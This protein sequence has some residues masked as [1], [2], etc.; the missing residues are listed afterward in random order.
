MPMSKQ[1]IPEILT[2]GVQEHQAV[3]A[4]LQIQSG[5]WEPG[6]LEV[7]QQRRYSTVYRLKQVNEEAT[8]VIAK[9]CRVAT[10]RI[11]QTIYEQ[12][13]PLTRMPALCC[14]GLQEESD[15]EFCWLFL[16]DAA[17]ARYSPQLPHNRGLAGR[18][19]AE[20]QLAAMSANLKSYLP[21]RELDHYLRLLRACRGMLLDHLGGGAFLAED[22]ALLRNIAAHLDALESLWGKVEKICEVMPRTLVH[23]DFVTKNLRVR[24]AAASPAL[25]VFDWE[26]AGWGVPATDLAQFIDRV[27]SPDLNLYCSILKGGQAH[28][29]LRDIQAVAACGNLLRMIDQIS[30]AT[31]DQE[32]VFPAQ[33]VKAIGLL[34]S[35]E[36]AILGA[37]RA[38]ERSW[39]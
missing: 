26:F 22:A 20:T 4:W 38:F 39:A 25:L 27:A 9:R 13:L 30:W 33:L 17:G 3:Q 12:L 15:G 23:G 29:D 18:W 10:A 5:S 28:L 21:D 35:Y 31:V 16:E 37:L 1:T 7:L 11:E 24:T 36:S 14:Y 32:F 2:E 6:S 34:R 8:R 19:L